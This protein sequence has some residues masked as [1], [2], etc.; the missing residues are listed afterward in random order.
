MAVICILLIRLF[1]QNHPMPNIIQNYGGLTRNPEN[2]NK[3]DKDSI[4]QNCIFVNL[5][6]IDI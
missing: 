2:N 6:E 1:T 3:N 5:F 4:I